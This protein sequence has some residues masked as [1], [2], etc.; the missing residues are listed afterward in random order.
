MKSLSLS[1]PHVL[2]MIG[3]PGVGKTYFAEHFA[4]T[5]KAPLVSREYISQQL[6]DHPEETKDELAIVSRIAGGQLIE[7]LKTQRSVIVDGGADTKA[8]RLALRKLAHDGGYEV[9]YVWVQTDP[10]TAKQRAT[11]Q[12]RGSTKK[13][14]SEAEYEAQLKRFSVPSPAEKPTVISGKHTYATQVKVV[15][16]RLVEPRAQEPRPAQQQTNT[17]GTGSRHILIR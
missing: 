7:L 16:K 5:F 2:V 11:R 15:L 17:D 4:E 3:A 10:A 13:P 8:D 9:L 6:F 1:K 14:L 12:V